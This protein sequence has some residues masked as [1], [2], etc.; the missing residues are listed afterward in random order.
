MTKDIT[1][2]ITEEQ[3]F[4]AVNEHDATDIF[5]EREVCGYGVYNERFYQTDGKYYVRY[6]LG[7]SCD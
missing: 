2:Q 4:K 5:S 3:Y 6:Q 7:S 1:R